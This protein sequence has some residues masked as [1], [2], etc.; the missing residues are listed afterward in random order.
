MPAFTPEEV[1]E[2]FAEGFVARDVEFL[3][4][5]YEPEASFTPQ[6]G[7]T[8]N[9]HE[10]IRQALTGFLAIQ[11]SFTIIDTKVI[12]AD[13]LALLISSWSLSGTGPNRSEVKLSRQTADVV[14]RQKD[15]NWLLAIDNPYG[16]QAVA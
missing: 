1:H 11:G 14:R 12:R 10:A 8:L 9:G 6:P 2:L 4:S 3:I 5:L 16:S 7:V 13:D 15:G